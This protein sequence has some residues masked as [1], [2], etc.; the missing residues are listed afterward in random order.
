MKYRSFDNFLLRTP[1]FSYQLKNNMFDYVDQDFFN[2]ALYLASPELVE[3]KKKN[4]HIR[5]MQ[6]TLYKYF[7]RSFSRCTPFGLFAGCSIGE[8]GTKNIIELKPLFEYTRCTRL[9]MNYICSLVRFLECDLQIKSK[10]K[11]FPNDSIYELGG[12]IRYVEYYYEGTKRF[13]RLVSIEK[14]EYIQLILCG[15]KLGATVKE[16]ASMIVDEEVTLDESIAFVENLISSQILKSELDISVTGEDPLEQLINKLGKIGDL[17]YRPELIKIRK[18]LKEIDNEP[19]G[20]VI[21]GYADVLKRIE[22]IGADFDQKYL[23]QIDMFKP[24]KEAMLSTSFVKE[25]NGVLAFLNVITNRSPNENLRKFK[26][27]FYNRYEEQEVPL[28]QVLD[29]ELGLG[30][31]VMVDGEGDVNLLIDDLV[32]PRIKNVYHS[33]SRSYLESMLLRKCLDAITSGKNTIIIEDKD[34]QMVSSFNWDDLPNTL[35]LMC[36]I[37]K[38][39]NTEKCKTIIK[40]VGGTSAANLLS[41]FCHINPQIDCLVKK[42]T[43]KEQEFEKDTVLAE[44]VHL[45]ESRIGNIILRP[46]FRNFEV[47]YLSNSCLEKEKQIEISDIL[48]SIKQNRIVLRSRKLNKEILPRLTNAHNYSFKS[49]PVY[50]FLCDLQHDEKCNRL[51][52]NCGDVFESLDYVPRIEYKNFILSL[53][54]W[55]FDGNELIG[56]NK[57]PDVE[58]AEKI[59]SFRLKHKM[60]R[61]VIF[62]EGD[63]ELYVDLENVLSVR[64]W[65]SRSKSYSRV[66]LSE[67]IFSSFR[68]LVTDGENYYT[69]EFIIPLYKDVT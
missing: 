45:P 49:M 34:I 32:L 20:Q 38:E 26:D 51:W 42:I 4:R 48:I 23:F 54:K 62:S 31:P 41:R 8:F 13:H 9:D 60:C 56:L 65:L 52:L 17:V 58:L 36:V 29:S 33:V 25:I 11:Y 46:I 47:R 6:Q 35:A 69:N 3:M 57:L 5:S 12:R 30:Y 28:V 50:R 21:S 63:N 22:C 39:L 1:L 16:L 7:S 2:E 27:E 55:N 61:E 43:Q 44:I 67:F 24:V 14:N 19:I 37:V 18:K 15:S 68:S 64:T 53:Q 66:T 10:L 40:S 59:K